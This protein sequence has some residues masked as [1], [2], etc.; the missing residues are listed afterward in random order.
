MV[1]FQ[2]HDT[3]VM[4]DWAHSVGLCDSVQEASQAAAALPDTGG[5]CFVPGFHGLQAPVLD[6]TATAGFIG[7][8]KHNSLSESLQ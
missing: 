7:I 4:V 5:L 8:S 1:L 2:V 6:P 3:G